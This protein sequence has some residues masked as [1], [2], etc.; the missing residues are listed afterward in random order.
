[1]ASLLLLMAARDTW[2]YTPA[3]AAELGDTE[4]VELTVAPGAFEGSDFWYLMSFKTWNRIYWRVA[5][6]AATGS[7]LLLVQKCPKK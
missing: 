7:V 1:M 6:H 3:V 5:P 2:V 4:R